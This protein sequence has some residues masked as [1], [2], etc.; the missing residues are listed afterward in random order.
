MRTLYIA[1]L[2]IQR[3]MPSQSS[4]IAGSTFAKTSMDIGSEELILSI[5]STGQ[6]LGF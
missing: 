1:L 4:E 3:L 2:V 6:G 5:G